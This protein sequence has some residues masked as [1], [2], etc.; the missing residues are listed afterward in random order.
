MDRLGVGAPIPESATYSQEVRLKDRL[1]KVNGKKRA[2]EDHDGDNAH[3]N[4]SDDEEESRAGAIQ[5]KTR[6]PASPGKK[7]KKKKRDGDPHPYSK[8]SP[9]SSKLEN[10]TQE[11]DTG[12]KFHEILDTDDDANSIMILSS[13][14]L[15]TSTKTRKKKSKKTHVGVAISPSSSQLPFPFPATNHADARPKSTD[16]SQNKSPQKTA[17]PLLHSGKEL[18]QSAT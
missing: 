15:P 11:K 16:H 8:P 12:A 13:P 17:L 3:K 2:R 5:R 9:G 6:A 18:S 4:Q 7:K 10:A 1:T 14:D